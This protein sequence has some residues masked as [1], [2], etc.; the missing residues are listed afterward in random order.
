MTKIIHEVITLM[1]NKFGL[2]CCNVFCF[3]GENFGSILSQVE[4]ALVVFYAPWCG[5]CKK[6][7]PEF[8]NAAARIKSEKV[9]IVRDVVYN[10]GDNTVGE[11]LRLN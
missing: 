6:I 1:V 5:H 4:N 7:K 10:S 2:I 3:L 9:F 8:E 11:R